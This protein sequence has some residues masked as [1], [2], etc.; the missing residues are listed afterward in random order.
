MNFFQTLTTWLKTITQP[1][2]SYQTERAHFGSLH[3]FAKDAAGNA[4]FGSGNPADNYDTTRVFTKGLFGSKTLD[5]ELGL[6]VHYRTSA[7]TG[8]YQN[9]QYFVDG[10]HQQNGVH[11]ASGDHTGRA[12]TNV[13]FSVWKADGDFSTT[14]ILI[15]TDSSTN[16]KFTVG[17]FTDMDNDGDIDAIVFDNG[18]VQG[19]GPGNGAEP[20][21][22]VADSFNWYFMRELSP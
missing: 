22:L 16:E 21:E 12:S 2:I 7:E 15:D 6:K 20:G 5:T 17:T 4:Y 13:D 9:G 10:G 14:K 1:V 11:G 18:F 3:D 19:V 8:D